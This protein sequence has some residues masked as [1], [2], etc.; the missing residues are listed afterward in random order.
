MDDGYVAP[1]KVTISCHYGDD[2]KCKQ[3]LIYLNYDQVTAEDIARIIESAFNASI[4]TV[5]DMQLGTTLRLPRRLHDD[6]NSNPHFSD[7]PKHWFGQ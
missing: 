1:D 4:V 2:E 5:R 7:P 3:I 6:I